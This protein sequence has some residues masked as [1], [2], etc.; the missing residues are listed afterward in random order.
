MERSAATEPI[1]DLERLDALD[2]EACA[3]ALAPL[4][5]GAPRFLR[6]LCRARPLG[7]GEALWERA[8]G[9]ALEMPEEDQVELVDAHPRLGAPPGTVSALSFR[10]QGYGHAASGDL[11]AE[12]EHLNEAYERRFGFRYCTFVAGR[13]RAELLPELEAR[14]RGQRDDELETALRAVVAIARDRAGLPSR[15]S[16]PGP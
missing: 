2:E 7:G 3:A 16:G 15:S 8:L 13:S 14:L 4:F 5:E 1:P 12:L 9:I 11:A 10:E 6:R